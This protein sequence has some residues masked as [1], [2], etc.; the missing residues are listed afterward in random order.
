MKVFLK[1]T[2]I[3]TIIDD[4]VI[5]SQVGLFDFEITLPIKLIDLIIRNL[6]YNFNMHSLQK[7]IMKVKTKQYFSSQSLTPKYIERKVILILNKYVRHT[8]RKCN[9][10]YQYHHKLYTNESSEI[11]KCSLTQGKR[12]SKML[13]HAYITLKEC[14]TFTVCLTKHWGFRIQ[15]FNSQYYSSPSCNPS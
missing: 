8:N 2:C 5:Y 3:N 4:S 11:S 6:Q 10:G 15:R 12:E 1:R 13:N 7:C 9:G 14:Q